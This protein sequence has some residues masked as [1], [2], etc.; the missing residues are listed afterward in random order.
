MSVTPT[1]TAAISIK[2]VR[3]D[4]ESFTAVRSLD[5]EIYP[6]EVFGLIGPNGAGKTSTFKVLST[7]LEPTYG[8]VYID[9][10]DIAE[11]PEEARRRLGSMQDLAPVP[12]DLKVWEFLDCFAHAYGLN[13][14]ERRQRINECLEMVDLVGKRDAMCQSL[15]RG[16]TQRVVLAKC[17][18]H[19]PR[20]LLLDEPASGMDPVSRVRLRDT[21]Q[22]LSRKGVAVLI[23][24]HILTE[25]S[26]LCSHIGILNHGELLDHGPTRDVVQRMTKDHSFRLIQIKTLG[27]NAELAAFLDEREG[28]LDL[29]AEESQ[30]RFKFSGSPQDQ[31]DLLKEI[32]Q[33]GLAITSFEETETNIEDI[34]LGLNTVPG[35]TQSSP[36]LNPAV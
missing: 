30:V 28:V 34:L 3:V 12:T 18:L 11:Q 35:S 17:L 7:L 19:S 16:M 10:I 27:A 20:V 21:I 2:G 24:S 4:Y 23:S 5:L 31:A 8:E 13:K 6:G 25:L 26:N 33:Q 22:E 32:I 29:V 36:P 14:A 15:S 1:S 9:G